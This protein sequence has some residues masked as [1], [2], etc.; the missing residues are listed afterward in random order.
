[1]SI[2]MSPNNR[3][4]ILLVA[5]I[6]IFASASIAQAPPK[7]ALCDSCHGKDGAQPILPSYPAIAG[8]NKEYLVSSL[9]AYKAG[10][11]KNT[12]AAVMTGQAAALTDEEIEALSAYY[13]EFK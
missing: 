11:R 5:A 2:S 7:A 4:K 13:A 1:M 9:K 3:L 6:G 12:M 8:Q 10:E